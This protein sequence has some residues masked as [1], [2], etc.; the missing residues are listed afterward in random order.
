ML[1]ERWDGTNWTIEST[2]NPSAT[3]LGS[4][5]CPAAS[6][7]IA[8]GSSGTVALAERW[9]GTAWSTLSVPSPAGATSSQLGAVACPAA[10]DCIAVGDYVS[11]NGQSMP[12]AEHW[13]GTGWS[14]QTFTD[15]TDRS[16]LNAI[17]CTSAT[18]CTAV[19]SKN[20]QQSAEGWNGIAWTPELIPEPMSTES[21][22]FGVSCASA[23]SCEAVGSTLPTPQSYQQALTEGWNGIAWTTQPTP[24]SPNLNMDAV[25][26]PSEAACIAVGSGYSLAEKW[27]GTS[28][29]TQS[30]PTPSGAA[31]LNSVSCSTP[32]LCTA[33]GEYDDAA[34]AESLIEHYS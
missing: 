9:D 16:I 34:G 32:D 25:S 28:W 21:F 4:V 7:C 17:S 19:G 26:C 8:V 20:R 31:F 23:R 18:A 33:V 24:S 14:A 13:D 30:V 12:L 10:N 3:Y 5:S 27:D 29:T 22:L 11:S 15:P 1:A 6:T 2:P